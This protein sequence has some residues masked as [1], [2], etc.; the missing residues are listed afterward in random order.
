MWLNFFDKII[1]KINVNKSKQNNRLTNNLNKIKIKIIFI[2]FNPKKINIKLQTNYKNT[3]K[4]NFNK[5]N[6]IQ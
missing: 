6:K 1:T 5:F 4:L 3:L 2:K